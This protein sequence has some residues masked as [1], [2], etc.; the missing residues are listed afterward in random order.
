MTESTTLTE[1]PA[2]QALSAH[3]DQIKDVHLRD[4]FAAD[5]RRGERLVAEATGLY[6]DYSKHRVTD[7]T[8]ELLVRLAE[9]SG[10]RE[11]ARLATDVNA[12][13][14]DIGARRLHTIIE[15]VLEELSFTAPERSGERVVIDGPF[16]LERVGEVA[17]DED[18]SAYIL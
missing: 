11:M 13:A 2:W 14:E 10:L 4:L 18:L 7:E 1:R 6:L 9:E 5:P 15:R 12:K 17:A 16:V 3:Y 8:I